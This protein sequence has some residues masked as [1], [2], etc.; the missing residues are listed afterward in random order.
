M[1]F[2]NSHTVKY[3]VFY[4]IKI[5]PFHKKDIKFYKPNRY[6]GGLKKQKNVLPLLSSLH[7]RVFPWL[8][9]F[10]SW[11]KHIYRR[12]SL[13]NHSF[14]LKSQPLNCVKITGGIIP[15]R[16]PYQVLQ[17]TLVKFRLNEVVPL[18]ALRNFIWID[19][20]CLSVMKN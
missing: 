17:H 13:S 9:L 10:F 11:T 3:I 15:T 1:D 2:C 8:R 4:A 7:W 18:T 14:P 12:N 20:T 6:E 19:L 16:V 5:Q